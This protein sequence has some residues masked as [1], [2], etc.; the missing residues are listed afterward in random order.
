MVF[1]AW[2]TVVTFCYEQLSI[3]KAQ[4]THTLCPHRVSFWII[5]NPTTK[6]M[7]QLWT[8]DG[9]LQTWLIEEFDDCAPA[10]IVPD[11]LDRTM[12]IIT[13]T[14][15][16]KKSTLKKLC[17]FHCNEKLPNEWWTWCEEIS[18]NWMWL[19][20]VRVDWVTNWKA[21]FHQKLKLY[22]LSGFGHFYILKFVRVMVFVI[23]DNKRFSRLHLGCYQK[24]P[25][26]CSATG[27]YSE[28]SLKVLAF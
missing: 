13:M 26:K 17:W 10:A 19:K 23:P 25:Q 16:Q 7:M 28:A 4:M 3:W 20:E 22:K 12:F 27:R 15:H 24:P 1:F 9:N 2:K 18:T 8:C 14:N 11:R 21:P 6:S 5:T